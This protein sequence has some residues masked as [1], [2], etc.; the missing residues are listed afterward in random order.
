MKNN[1]IY[2]GNI[3]D[4]P[5]MFNKSYLKLSS[6][7]FFYFST[8]GAFL[9]FWPLYLNHIN[10]TPYEI[11]IITGA[12]IGTKIIAPN[13]WGWIA[14][15]TG[16][17][18]RVIQL[19]ALSCFIIF[20]FASSIKS[21]PDMLLLIFF[22]S[23]F[24]NASLPQ[25]EAV[26]MNTLGSSYNKYSQIRL[27]G[28]FG[29]IISVISL[30]ILTNRYG[31]NIVPIC[32]LVFLFLTFITTLF[33]NSSSANS[34]KH[35]NSLMSIVFKPAVIGIL[36]SC[37]LMQLSHGPFYAFFAIYLSENSYNTNLIG[38]IWSLGVIAEILIF[39]KISSWIPKYGLQNLFVISFLF[40]TS[41]WLLISFF[42]ENIIIV[43]LATLFHAI[44]YGMYHAVSIS[45][46][47]E[48]FTGELQGR[49]QALYSSVSFGLG[50]SIG[51][52][53]SGYLW[54]SSGGSAVYLYASL[55]AFLGFIVALILVKSNY[56]TI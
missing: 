42:P 47:H 33:V 27:W 24:W 23:F 55:F 8:L 7:Y 5:I 34:E 14:D 17:R 41:R 16:L 31:I 37:F 36:L 10:F 49:G 38:F 22:F 30:S 56:R 43:I 12:M 54:E 39:I 50:G 52:F 26:T 4:S 2:K 44:T 28:S 51:S 20:L 19:G 45:L 1:K 13:L 29:F 53:Y 3:L 21:F 11:G 48:Y 32:I 18:H 6:F 35:N 15:K 40:A 25:F 46:I 9:P